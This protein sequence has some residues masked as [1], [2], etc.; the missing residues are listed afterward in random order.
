MAWG[1]ERGEKGTHRLTEWN[2]VYS[3]YY[4]TCNDH[5]GQKV[6]LV[7]I[8]TAAPSSWPQKKRH[9][10]GER[11]CDNT[12]IKRRVKVFWWKGQFSWQ[13]TQAC[14]F[15]T[16]YLPR[17]RIWREKT[18]FVPKN[19]PRSNRA[20]ILDQHSP[21]MMYCM[22]GA[23]STCMPNSYW[24]IWWSVIWLWNHKTI[25]IFLGYIVTQHNIFA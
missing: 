12:H 6:C 1:E 24:H 18:S 19:N 8:H 15:P 16:R 25:I 17:L 7:T 13:I 5:F 9:L 14:Y 3:V 11:P 20:A 10:K 22:C 2:T 4:D 21:S 23:T